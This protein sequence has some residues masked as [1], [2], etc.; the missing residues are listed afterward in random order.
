[1]KTVLSINESAGIV[2]I[3]HCGETDLEEM[4]LARQQAGTLLKDSGFQRL[5]IDVREVAEPPTTLDNFEISSSLHQD[6]PERVRVAILAP[7]HHRQSTRFSENVTHNRGF[8]VRAFDDEST[9]LAWLTN[10]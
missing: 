1:M 6:L 5:L 2:C 4:F 10:D 9:A 3:Y 7:P 8:N